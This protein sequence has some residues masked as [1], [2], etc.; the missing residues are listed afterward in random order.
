MEVKLQQLISD[1]KQKE[2]HMKIKLETLEERAIKS[3]ENYE[4]TEIE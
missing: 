1:F 2:K 3:A 4:R